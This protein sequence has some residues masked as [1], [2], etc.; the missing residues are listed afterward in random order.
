MKRG[1]APP[2][3]GR[4]RDLNGRE[5]REPLWRSRSQERGKRLFQVEK[6]GESPHKTKE[7]SLSMGKEIGR[8]SSEKDG[9]KTSYYPNWWRS[10]K[11]LTRIEEKRDCVSWGGLGL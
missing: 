10:A 4:K 1:R 11:I 8:P 7:T 6:G 2:Q 5:G 3:D 9:Q